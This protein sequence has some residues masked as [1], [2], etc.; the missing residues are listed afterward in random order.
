[1][2][3]RMTENVTMKAIKKSIE[4]CGDKLASNFQTVARKTGVPFSI[5]EHN[6]HGKNQ[7]GF[8]SLTGRNWRIFSNKIGAEIRA[9]NGLFNDSDK[10]KFAWLFEHLDSILKFAGKC[11]RSD[12]TEV[13]NMAREWT[14]V[15]V[16]MGYEPTPYIHVFHMHLWKSVELYGPQD[17]FSGELVEL[18]N[19]SIKQTH[20]RRTDRKNPKL[21]LQTQLRIE[22]QLRHAENERL[23]H[24]NKRKR[25]AGPLHPWQGEGV[26]SFLREKR[27]REER[28]R[29]QVTMDQE[30]PYERLTLEELKEILFQRTGSKTRKKNREALIAILINID[31][32]GSSTE[33]I[34]ETE[35]QGSCKIFL[36]FLTELYKNHGDLFVFVNSHFCI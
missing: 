6:V 19:D 17:R 36:V 16:G 34:E 21:T 14:L 25:K 32:S 30:G 10:E 15:Y 9:S 22:L 2:R 27:A 18:A 29:E 1:M 3:M 23:E 26:K 24:M 12:A 20:H 33:T 7:I 31:Q 28:E 8:T 4:Y 13:A 5:Y 11:A 35:E